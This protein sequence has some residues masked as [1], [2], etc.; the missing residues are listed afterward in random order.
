MQNCEAENAMSLMTS[1]EY[2][3]S[4]RDGRRVW[5]EGERVAD[6]TR[7]AAFMPMIDAMSRIYD[8]QRE[9]EFAERLTFAGADG[10]RRSRFYKL[11]QTQDDLVM[12]RHMTMAVLDE[13]SPVIDRFGDETVTPLFVLADR[14]ATL[15]RFD[16]RYAANV[17]R[18]LDEL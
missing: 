6:V 10:K 1:R 13:V 3:E 15:D 17:L 16:K 8:M 12:R 4:L 5:I 18:W 11:P 9:P 2:R 14:K 7:H